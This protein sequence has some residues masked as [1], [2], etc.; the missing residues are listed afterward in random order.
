MM[1]KIIVTGATSMIGSAIIRSCLA[2]GSVSKIYT[3]VRPASKKLDHL[4]CDDRIHI[5]ECPVDELSHLPEKIHD[6]ADVFYHIAWG[7]TGKD[8]NRNISAQ[9]ANITYT[10][11]AVR[12]AAAL[13]CT[14]FIGAGSQ[15]EYG[16][17]HLSVIR[18]DT[19]VNPTQPYGIAKYAAG[20]L[21]YA[22]ARNLGLTFIWVRIFSVFGPYEKPTTMISSS[23][24]KML[25]GESPSFTEATQTWDFLYADDAGDAFLEIGEKVTKSMV[26]CLGSGQGRSLRS[27]IL[28]MRD[29][30]APALPIHFGEIPYGPDGP[31]SICADIRSLTEDTGWKPKRSFEDGIREL[32]RFRS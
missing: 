13:G 27:Y 29:I 4:P 20:K 22:E 6:T 28:A 1:K 14:K 7:L 5:V 8:R 12:S 16:N 26:Y 32:L 9:A 18:P 19:P 25:N 21:G 2:S 17:T 23:L 3:V 30:A 15:A 10:V 31:L 24:S 11:D